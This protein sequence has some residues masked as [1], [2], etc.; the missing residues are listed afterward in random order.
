MSDIMNK[1]IYLTADREAGNVI[2]I[3]ESADL[4]EA[5][6]RSYEEADLKDGSYTPDFYEIQ[7]RTAYETLIGSRLVTLVMPENFGA[8]RDNHAPSESGVA[9]FAAVERVLL[10][11][12]DFTKEFDATIYWHEP[13]ASEDFTGEVADLID[14][15][16]PTEVCFNGR[17]YLF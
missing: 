11:G 1:T 4:A 15:D 8:L 12:Y 7:E 10:N 6:I 16:N 9:W 17:Y 5:K 2:D 3:L 14:W 13:V